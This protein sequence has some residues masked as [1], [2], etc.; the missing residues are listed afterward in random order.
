MQNGILDKRVLIFAAVGLSGFVV[1]S[2]VFSVLLLF[3]PITLDMARIVAFLVAVAVTYLGNRHFTF[4]DNCK[5]QLT[6][7]LKYLAVACFSAI[8][9]L[10]VFKLLTMLIGQDSFSIAI[11]FTCG[12]LVGMMSNFFLNR[13]LVF[14]VA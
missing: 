2:M 7:F 8:P 10:L 13:A 14:K 5:G 6:Q 9:N 12:I 11:A 4:E 3:Y 1:D